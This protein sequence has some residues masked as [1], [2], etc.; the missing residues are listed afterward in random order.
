MAVI[1]TPATDAALVKTSLSNAV[2]PLRVTLVP[3][4]RVVGAP[5]P[6]AVN[7]TGTTGHAI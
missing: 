1:A 5:Q 3:G 7:A 6:I 4:G 2:L